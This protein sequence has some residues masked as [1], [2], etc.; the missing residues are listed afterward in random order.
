MPSVAKICELEAS[1]SQRLMFGCGLGQR[2][3]EGRRSFDLQGSRE[4][5]GSGS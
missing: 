3:S 1:G 5:S 2:D 4:T